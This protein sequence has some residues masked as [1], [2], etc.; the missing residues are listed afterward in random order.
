MMSL[1]SQVVVGVIYNFFQNQLFSAKKGGGAYMND[2]PIH[3]SN[4]R[5]N[6]S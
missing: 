2:Q 4:I 1:L 5:G 6:T 3:V